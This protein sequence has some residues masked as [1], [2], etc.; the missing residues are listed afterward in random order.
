[1][2]QSVGLRHWHQAI[3]NAL[4]P[5]TGPAM[6]AADTAKVTR[7]VSRFQSLDPEERNATDVE[8][9]YQVKSITPN[10]K[11]YIL[12]SRFSERMSSDQDNLAL[13]MAPDIGPSNARWRSK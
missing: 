7:Q 11:T 6:T 3:N 2:K 4:Y 5:M 13:S 10:R 1:M 12:Y 8:Q 9:I